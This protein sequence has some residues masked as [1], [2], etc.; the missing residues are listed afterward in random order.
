MYTCILD[1]KQ[2]KWLDRNI[3]LVVRAYLSNCKKLEGVK[4][5][6]I[7]IKWGNLDENLLNRVIS[8]KNVKLGGKNWNLLKIY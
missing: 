7:L 6:T 5:G 2:S 4:M 3:Y 8:V 1:E